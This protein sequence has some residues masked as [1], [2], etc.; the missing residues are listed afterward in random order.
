MHVQEVASAD[1][2]RL[3]FRTVPQVGVGSYQ[4]LGAACIA[5]CIRIVFVPAVCTRTASPHELRSNMDRVGQNHAYTVY[6][7]YFWQGNDQIYGRIR[8]ICT[9]LANPKYGWFERPL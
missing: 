8:C 9:V 4:G 3:N 2:R 1:M 7:R 5:L 6:M